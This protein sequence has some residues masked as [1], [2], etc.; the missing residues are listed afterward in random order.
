MTTSCCIDVFQKLVK[1]YK[2]FYHQQIVIITENKI[3][4][5]VSAIIYNRIRRVSIYKKR[6]QRYCFIF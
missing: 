1:N 6:T 4:L 5:H 3:L 2:Q